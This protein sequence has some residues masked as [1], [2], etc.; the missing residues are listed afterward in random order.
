MAAQNQSASQQTP[1]ATEA[2]LGGPTFDPAKWLI[3]PA[4]TFESLKMGEVFR[5][6]SRTLTEAHTSAFQAVSLD[7]NP[8]HYDNEYAKKHGIKT[9]LVVPLEVLS[10]AIPGASLFTLAIGEVL[11]AWTRVTADYVGKC[12]VGD[13]LYPALEI[14]GLATL[15]DKGQVTMAITIL[16]QRG[17]VVLTGQEIFELKLTPGAQ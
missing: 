11:I 6:P 8:L 4:R 9:A 1:T 7:N 13:T 17:E 2:V 10:F 16:N 15:E 3:V 14:A 12:F 5:M